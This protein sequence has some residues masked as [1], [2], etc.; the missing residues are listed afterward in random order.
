MVERSFD[1]E[2]EGWSK[3]AEFY[4]SFGAFTQLFAEDAL[5]LADL[6]PGQQVIDAA[7]GTGCLA[8]LAARTGA[9]VLAVDFSEGMIDQLRM[10]V[11]Q[12]KADHIQ[13]AVMD[14]QALIVED[15][16][17][18]AAF[19]VFGLCFFPDRAAGFRELHRVLKPG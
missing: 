4:D 12:S 14:G 2:P 8:F 7:T 15:H 5:R 11:A 3:A 1:Q 6:K 17:F 10:K 9:H 18:D 13:A 19:S 16:S